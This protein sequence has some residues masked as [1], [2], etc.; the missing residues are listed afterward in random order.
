MSTKCKAAL[1]AAFLSVH[2]S[3]VL[4]KQVRHGPAT[5]RC[6]DIQMAPLQLNHAAYSSSELALTAHVELESHDQG[7]APGQYAVFYQDRA[8]V[9]AAKII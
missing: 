3:C 5:Y 6:K 2:S 9:G 7:L 8:C 1:L 4:S